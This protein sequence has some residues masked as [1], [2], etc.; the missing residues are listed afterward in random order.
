MKQ[1]I[2]NKFIF[3]AQNFTAEEIEAVLTQYLIEN[4]QDPDEF[5]LAVVNSLEALVRSKEFI[6]AAKNTFLGPKGES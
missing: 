5:S 3:L 4:I 2:K 1:V 6:S